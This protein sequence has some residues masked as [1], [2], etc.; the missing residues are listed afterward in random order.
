M[1]KIYPAT[2]HRSRKDCC[3]FL[4]KGCNAPSTYTWRNQCLV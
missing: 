3:T 2:L 4:R 1:G